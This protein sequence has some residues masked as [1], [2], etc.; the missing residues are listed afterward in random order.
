MR[1]DHL[2]AV[3]DYESSPLRIHRERLHLRASSQETFLEAQSAHF[4]FA[5][6]DWMELARVSS[7]PLEERAAY[8]ERIVY[9]G[10]GPAG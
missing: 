6:Q 3:H 7:R 9:A 5:I 4:W 2:L 10:P 1:P 8:F